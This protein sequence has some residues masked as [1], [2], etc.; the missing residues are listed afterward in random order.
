[1]LKGMEKGRMIPRGST[2]RYAR[3]ISDDKSKGLASG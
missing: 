1:M 2:N 3:N